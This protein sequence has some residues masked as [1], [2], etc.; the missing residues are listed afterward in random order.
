MG[1]VWDHALLVGR[2]EDDVDVG[3]HREGAGRL[4]ARL[5]AVDA[6]V[7]QRHR[8]AT[9]ARERACDP[10]RYANGAYELS[11]NVV[12]VNGRT[13]PGSVPVIRVRS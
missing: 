3:R 11:L 6:A 2:I 5:E 1:A 9:V 8:H 10:S 12:D 4:L 13:T 7:G